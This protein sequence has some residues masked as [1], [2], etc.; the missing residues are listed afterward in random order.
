MRR[1]LAY[2]MV[3]KVTWFSRWNDGGPS[4]KPALTRRTEEN[5]RRRPAPLQL[6]AN[7]EMK[8]HLR[9]VIHA[10]MQCA[11]GYEIV[12]IYQIH[13]AMKMTLITTKSWIQANR[14]MPTHNVSL[15]VDCRGVL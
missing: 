6:E 9:Y 4:I 8:T 2:R 3:W 12:L 13:T 1:D 7:R 5:E 14:V 11:S 15:H 10:S